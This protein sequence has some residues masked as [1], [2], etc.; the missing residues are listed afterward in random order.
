MS[1]LYPK[2]QIKFQLHVKKNQKIY[3]KDLLIYT[4]KCRGKIYNYNPEQA[5]QNN[6]FQKKKKQLNQRQLEK[7]QRNY[8]KEYMVY[9]LHDILR[10]NHQED[11]T[12]ENFYKK[13]SNK[14]ITSQRMGWFDYKSM[15]IRIEPKLEHIEELLKESI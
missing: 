13:I 10:L 3:I 5:L 2:P 4:L 7:Q 1:S 15:T 12:L 14:E 8:L 9:I 11:D 6:R